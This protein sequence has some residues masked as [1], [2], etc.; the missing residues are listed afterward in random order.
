VAQPVQRDTRGI[1]HPER[2]LQRFKLSRYAP[3][4]AVARFVD[5]YWLASWQLPPGESHEQEVLVHPV[6]NLVFDAERATV[7]GV[8]RR[9][10]TR[11]LEG[12]GRVLGVMFRPGGFR[13]FL[14][15]PVSTITDSMLPLAAVLPGGA[16]LERG[17]THALA[18]GASD[19]ELVAVIDGSLAAQVPLEPQPSE[20]TTAWA[21]QAARDR[22]VCRVGD[23]AGLAGVSVRQLERSFADHIGVPPKWVIRRYRLY[24]IA[25]RAARSEVNDWARLAAELAYAD[26][27]HL[28]RDFA[29]TV[30]ESPERYARAAR[31]A[32]ARY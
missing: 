15:R 24:E 28:V 6:V 10:F 23:L 12:Y 3:S 9:R 31:T 29:A 20:R 21:D 22:D 16:E 32:I 19:E 11:K 4:T 17:V 5:R 8:W 30:G 18:G 26:Q 1:L 13:P 7:S 27:S 14:G 2:G 25:E